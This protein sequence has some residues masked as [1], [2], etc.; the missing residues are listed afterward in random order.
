MSSEYSESLSIPLKEKLDSDACGLN[1][2]DS[3]R[4][5]KE[6]LLTI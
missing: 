1:D 6:H 5:L 4:P 2:E 3:V